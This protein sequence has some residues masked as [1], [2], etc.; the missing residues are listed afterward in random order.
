[1]AVF[2]G[3]STLCDATEI[4]QYGGAKA[5]W[6][7]TWTALNNLNDPRDSGGNLD[8]V[9]DA[10]N[11]G[12]YWAMDQE[13]VYFRMRMDVGTVDSNTYRDAVFVFIDNT[14]PTSNPTPDYAFTWDSKGSAEDHGLEM[15]VPD[16][17]GPDWNDTRMDDLD[18]L[19][20]KKG[21][22]DINGLISGNT[23][24]TEE[25]YVRSVDSQATANFGTTSFLDFAVAWGYLRTY[26]T[27]DTGQSWNVA[28]GSVANATDHNFI[29]EDVAGGVGPGNSVNSGW[30]GTI[31]TQEV[32][33]PSSLVVLSV[34][35]LSSYVGIQFRRRRKA[36]AEPATG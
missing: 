36:A 13:Y 9:G 15:Q 2:A 17:T 11:P 32:P 30:S 1:M 28:F 31:N 5:V 3:V 8:F 6:P 25:G 14:S 7:T 33:E 27:L 23:Y 21:P 12:A 24:R 4:A 22:E 18:G 29:T 20:S 16:R 35:A 19:N 10:T 26:T 34:V